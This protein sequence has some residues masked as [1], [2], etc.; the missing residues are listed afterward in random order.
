MLPAGQAWAMGLPTLSKF[1]MCSSL[2]TG[3][4]VIGWLGLVRM[5]WVM[6]GLVSVPSLP[7]QLVGL[8]GLGG[9]GTLLSRGTSEFLV[10]NSILAAEALIL[11]IMSVLLLIGTWK[12]LP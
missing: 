12:V 8:L 1:C 11:L 9:A 2:R 3:C 7:L 4:F 5:V 6:F 10:I